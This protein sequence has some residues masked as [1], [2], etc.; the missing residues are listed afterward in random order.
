M[1]LGVVDAL[2]WWD[3]YGVG[4]ATVRATGGGYD[5]AVRYPTVSRPALASPFEIIVTRAGGFDG[6]ITLAVD[7]AYIEMWDENGL[8]PA[9]AAETS[10]G[11]LIEW[12]FDPPSGDTLTIWY[13]ARIEPAAQSGRDG[14]VAVLEDGEIVVGGDVLDPGDALME[15]IARATVIFVFL[16]LLTRGLKRRAL[17]DLTPFELILLVTMGDIVQQ[18]ITQEDYSL[19]GAVLAG[20]TFAFWISVLSFSTWRS[21]R[22]AALVSG[23]PIV[24]VQ[25]GQPIE[26]TLKVERLPARRGARSGSPARHRRSR[27]GQAGRARAERSHLVHRAR[28]LTL[29]LRPSVPPPARRGHRTTGSCPGPRR[30]SAWSGSRTRSG[31]R[32]RRCPDRRG[33]GARPT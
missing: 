20:S 24:I 29:R 16:L 10:R 2:G 22:V 11:D 6:P 9:P 26:R 5:L 21:R 19:T 27:P 31:G 7:Q 15:I 4:D 17:S 32:W 18:G 28:R 13:D 8:V 12:E 1:A 25:D 14:S 30:H 23:V 3:T 33:D